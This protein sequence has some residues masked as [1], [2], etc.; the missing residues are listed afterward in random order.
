[1][2]VANKD[3]VV[4]VIAFFQWHNFKAFAVKS[5]AKTDKKY[6]TQNKKSLI[7]SLILK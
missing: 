3:M 4:M 5:K 7:S 6:Y 2:K 1:M